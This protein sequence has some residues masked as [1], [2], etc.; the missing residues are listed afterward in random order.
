MTF[1]RCGA[2][3]IGPIFVAGSDGSP[4]V[5]SAVFGDHPV[6]QVVA[7]AAVDDHARAAGAVLAH[8]RETGEGDVV[9]DE[10]EVTRVGHHHVRA[11]AAALEHDLLEVALRC[12][13]QE[14]PADLGRAGERERVHAHVAPSAWP[15]RRAETRDDVQDT[16]RH[17]RLGGQLREADRAER[18]QLG[19]LDDQA[20]PGGEGRGGLPGGHH[21]RE[22]PRQDR[23][24]HAHRLADD[25]AE[26]LGTARRDRVEQLVGGLRDPAEGLDGLGQVHVAAVGDRL[27][28]LERVEL[29]E[30]LEVRLDQVR[31]A[32][33]DDL[34][35]GGGAARPAAVL[36]RRPS[37]R[38]R[39]VDVGGVAGRDLGQRPARGGVL[40]GEAFAAR[41][42]TE[43]AVDERV[44]TERRG[45]GCGHGCLL[46]VSIART[47]PPP[48]RPPR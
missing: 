21:E 45:G 14:Q 32:E 31:E 11:L 5:H 3:I 4:T 29:R 9:R 46:R 48:R 37:G 36:E 15:A 6:E 12:V 35:L 13:A 25:H 2:S 44:G 34:A 8:I 28:R 22:V 20:V 47:I 1:A 42:R 23:G 26:R 7:D 10:V 16:I 41:G 39:G 30:L 27:A 43:R 19:R 24:D 17:A 18:R 38:H 33:H 40:G